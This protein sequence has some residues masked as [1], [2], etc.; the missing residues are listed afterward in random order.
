MNLQLHE[1]TNV[2]LK[3]KYRTMLKSGEVDVDDFQNDRGSSAKKSRSSSSR[4]GLDSDSE[5]E[6]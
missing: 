6:N 1:R 2:D 5:D 3:D 4:L